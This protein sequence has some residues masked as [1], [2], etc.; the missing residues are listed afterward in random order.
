M[1]ALRFAAACA[2]AATLVAI[3]AGGA[4]AQST[5]APM[6]MTMAPMPA[7]APALDARSLRARRTAK[8]FTLTGQAEVKD[9]C[10]AARFDIFEGTVFPA[11]F[12]VTQFR[13]PGTLGLMCAQ[14]LTWVTVQLRAVRALSTQATVTVHTLRRPSIVVPIK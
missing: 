5:P 7:G 12:N 13:R 10:Q 2:G 11:Q 4:T 3:G 8:G 6:I 14:R 9:A 1:H